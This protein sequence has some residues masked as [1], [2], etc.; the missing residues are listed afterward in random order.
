MTRRTRKN[1]TFGFRI[2]RLCLSFCGWSAPKS[3]PMR[4]ISQCGRLAPSSTSTA[5][6]LENSLAW[7][8]PVRIPVLSDESPQDQAFQ[9]IKGKRPYVGVNKKGHRI[10][11]SDVQAVEHDCLVS[12]EVLANSV[13][14][15]TRDSLNFRKTSRTRAIH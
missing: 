6:A 10:L 1:E 2:G 7:Y 5:R 12:L 13:R 14:I 15:S 4:A 8:F 3:E 9:Q 11:E